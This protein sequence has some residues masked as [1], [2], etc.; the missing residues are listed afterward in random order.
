MSKD[1]YRN[2]ETEVERNL[3]HDMLGSTPLTINL[4]RKYANRIKFTDAE[5]LRIAQNRTRFWAA[6]SASLGAKLSVWWERLSG[7]KVRQEP[8]RVTGHELKVLLS[9]AQLEDD[10]TIQ[11]VHE[12]K[13]DPRYYKVLVDLAVSRSSHQVPR[14]RP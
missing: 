6:Q 7:Q 5:I 1:N 12:Y 8:F 4:S 11:S 9:V 10:D 2:V 3:I 13:V 14:K